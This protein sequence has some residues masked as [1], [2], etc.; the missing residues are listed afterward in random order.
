MTIEAFTEWYRYCSELLA[1]ADENNAD[2]GKK[3]S[4]DQ[5]ESTKKYPTFISA[6]KY[7]SYLA[8]VLEQ[9]QHERDSS[10]R[11]QLLFRAI[12]PDLPA[13]DVLKNFCV[14]EVIGN[15]DS[16]YQIAVD[17]LFDLELRFHNERVARFLTP[18][19]TG[20]STAN[21]K[22]KGP[23]NTSPESV[24]RDKNKAFSDEVLAAG[25]RLLSIKSHF[26]NQAVKGEN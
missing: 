22:S 6:A 11:R 1:S 17:H 21:A 10:Q 25:I 18:G 2:E 7:R 19:T 13:D 23:K 15:L 5:A 3:E 9:F 8:G 16:F 26:Y 20:A 4:E 14:H 12:I 24:E